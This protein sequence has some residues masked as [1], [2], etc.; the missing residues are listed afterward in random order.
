MG[1]PALAAGITGLGVFM[2]HKALAAS[3]GEIVTFVVGLLAGGIVY[4]VLLL[5]FKCIREKDLYALPGGNIIGKIGKILH[6]F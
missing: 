5:V 3:L 1:L 2:L 4:L 6:L